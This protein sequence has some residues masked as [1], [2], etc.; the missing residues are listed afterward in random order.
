M[1]QLAKRLAEA[2]GVSG[3]E[4]EI[5]NVIR[6]EISGLV[7]E[8]QVDALGNLVALKKGRGTGKRVM[9]AA[10]MDQIGLMVTYIDEKGFMRFTNVGFIYSLASWGGQV[11]FTDGTIG[12]VGVDGRAD[13]RHKLPELRD[14]YIDVGAASKAEVRQKVGAVCGFWPGFT[15]QGSTWFSPNMDDRVGCVVL[16]QLLQ[17]LKNTAIDHDLYAVFTTQE[18]VGTRGARTAGYAIDPEIAIALDVTMT[19]DIPHA[20]PAMDVGIGK[21]VAIKVMDSGMIA[22]P[23]LNRRLIE[24]AEAATIPYQLE[25]LQGGS[26]DAY[27][28]QVGRAGVPATVLSIPSRHVHTP[29]QIVDER[30][31]R[32]TVDLLKAF[33]GQAIEI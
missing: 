1:Q 17:E 13:P 4:D 10:H 14:Y 20:S 18:E 9:L 2:F 21:G 29:S 23:G 16:V 7:D 33:L 26:T 15:G 28:I 27:A 5:R 31:V 8:V 6:E 19:G 12:T 3:F 22:H 32:A 11:R 25:V 30:D 24:T